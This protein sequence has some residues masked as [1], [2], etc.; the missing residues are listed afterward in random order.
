VDFAL[1][2][3]CQKGDIVVT[4][5]YGVAAMALSKGEYSMFIEQKSEEKWIEWNLNIVIA[6]LCL[7]KRK[8]NYF[9]ASGRSRYIWAY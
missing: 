6:L 5:D 4:Q 1:I 8:K 2:N 3:L 7:T 9:F